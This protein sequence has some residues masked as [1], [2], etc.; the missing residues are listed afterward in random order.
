MINLSSSADDY[1]Y[2]FL[3]VAFGIIITLN[4]KS[5]KDTQ[6]LEQVDADIRKDLD[7]HKN[8]SASLKQD[9]AY[10]KNQLKQLQSEK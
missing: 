9:L 4:H 6:T 2:L 10:T 5:Y 7:Y 1:V 8:L 3:G